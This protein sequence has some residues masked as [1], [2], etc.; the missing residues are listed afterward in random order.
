MSPK[1]IFFDIDGTLVPNHT[2]VPEDTRAALIRLK[3]NGHIPVICTGRT[4][5]IMYARNGLEEL[6]LPGQIC[7]AGSSV[8][9]QGKTVY[10]H[11]LSHDLLLWTASLLNRMGC[12]TVFEGPEHLYYLPRQKEHL[13]QVWGS[14]ID[15]EHICQPFDM[16]TSKVQKLMASDLEQLMGSPELEA[17][18]KYFNV[19]FYK[20]HPVA[21]L[22]PRDVSKA[23][24]IQR[25]LDHL[26]VPLEDTYAFGDGPNDLEMLQYVRYGV[27]MGN[28]D[29]RV[30]AAARYRT[31]GCEEGGISLALKRF[32][33][34]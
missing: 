28:A 17:L 25:L 4:K 18:R 23:T 15:M 6:D 3:E 30:L 1:V 32:G 31:G 24:G 13:R 9:Y 5:A 12:Q 14:L 16:D 22:I 7:G 33:L 11:I 21:E 19:L 27:A 20:D 26:E 29:P 2:T 8:F 34:I 10:Q